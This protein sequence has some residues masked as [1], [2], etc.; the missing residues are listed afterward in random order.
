MKGSVADFVD[1]DRVPDRLELSLVADPSVVRDARAAVAG[2]ASS[3]G[4]TAETLSAVKLAVSEAVTNAVV[5]AYV[6]AGEPGT[7]QVTAERQDGRLCIA[8]ADEGRGMVPRIDSPG[9]GLGLPMISNLASHFE[10]SCEPQ[11]GTRVVMTFA[12]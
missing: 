11:G 1:D 10:I 3:L 2:F 9:S 7:V 5:H 8:V 6:D 4:A 12:V